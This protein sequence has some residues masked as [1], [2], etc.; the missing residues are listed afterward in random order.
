MGFDFSEMTEE[1]TVRP[2]FTHNLDRIRKLICSD[3]KLEAYVPKM[4]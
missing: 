3:E 2:E 4:D 1:C